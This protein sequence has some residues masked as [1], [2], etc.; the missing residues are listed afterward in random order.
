[1]QFKDN[2]ERGYLN[3]R[4]AYKGT[5]FAEYQKLV[6]GTDSMLQFQYEDE[7]GNTLPAAEVYL[8]LH[9]AGKSFRMSAVPSTSGPG[10]RPRPGD[11]SEEIWTAVRQRVQA[12]MSD[13]ARL[14]VAEMQERF[15]DTPLLKSWSAVQL[16]Y[17]QQQPQRRNLL[18]LLPA[19]EAQYGNEHEISIPAKTAAD[20]SIIL[21]RTAT[22]SAMLDIGLL[23]EQADAFGSIAAAAAC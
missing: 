1:M 4:T 13:A 5:G 15:P 10:R 3:E 16:Q 6:E 22:V 14:V 17:W 11:V 12:A 2:V 20:R 19:L 23:T 8:E 21:A 18:S 7:D 9:S